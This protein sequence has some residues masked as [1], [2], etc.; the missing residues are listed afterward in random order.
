ME[1]AAMRQRNSAES[2][3]KG[4]DAQSQAVARQRKSAGPELPSPVMILPTLTAASYVAPACEP[5]PGKSLSEMIA[6]SAA[7]TQVDPDLLRAVVHQES[8][9]RPC[10]VSRKGAT[11]LMQLM[12]D[13]A[14]MLGV[15]D[16]FNPRENIHAG[17]SLLRRLLDHFDGDQEKALAAYNA[18]EANVERAGGVPDFPETRDYVAAILRALGKP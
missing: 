14:A 5:M 9:D 12:P 3:N 16:V 17:A 8:A 11:G 1:A 7:S 6:D 4:V 10:A 2:M 18:G 13:T 15:S